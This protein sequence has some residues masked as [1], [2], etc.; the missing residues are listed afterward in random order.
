M[1]E[2]CSTPQLCWH[3]PQIWAKY[4]SEERAFFHVTIP[5]AEERYTGSFWDH[6]KTLLLVDILEPEPP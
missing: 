1:P 4:I 6:E 2:P 3:A 5:G